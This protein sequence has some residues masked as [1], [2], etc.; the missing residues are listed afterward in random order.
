ME[1]YFT[2]ISFILLALISCSTTY[3]YFLG[4]YGIYLFRKK[5]QPKF[6]DEKIFKIFIPA[7]NEELII[8]NL[9]NSLQ[10][11]DYKSENYEIIVIADNC[12]DDTAEIARGLNVTALER[13]D[14]INKGKG[15]AL[16]WA[17]TKYNLD[18]IDIVCIIDADCIVESDFLKTLAGLIEEGHKMIQTYFGFFE[19]EKTAYAYLEYLSNLVENHIYYNPR[20]ALG[21]YGSLLGSG[22]A[23]KPEVLKIAPWH[24]HSIVEDVDQS[25]KF[26]ENG[27]KVHHCMTTKVY[28]KSTRYFNQAFKQRVRGSSG[29][30]QI[31]NKDFI[32]LLKIGIMK[33]D[34]RLV[35][36]TFS[37]LI[38]SRPSL[39][40][41]SL[42]GVILGLLG[43][44]QMISL[45]W[46]IGLSTLIVIYLYLGLLL[47]PEQGPKT[48]AIILSPFFGAW[49]LIVQVL[50]AFGYKKNKWS[51]TERIIDD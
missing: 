49:L 14:P 8:S 30:F 41:I 29:V 17:F 10:N 9:I 13:N 50:S 40:Y 33:K 43:N 5:D 20:S 22:M 18:E 36:Y 24:S 37:L 16:E 7:Y 45:W 39:I 34:W 31:I 4:I 23:F 3:L 25:N 35:E 19:F 1:F 2:L 42:L 48:K 12:K 6:N 15:Q 44:Y 11:N 46:G 26:T 28:Q 27:I 32:R 38:L 47:K 51:R 21:L